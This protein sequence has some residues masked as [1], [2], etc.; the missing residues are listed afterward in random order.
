MSYL[1]AYAVPVALALA[2]TLDRI[3]AEPPASVHPIVHFGTV[4]SY[5]DRPWNRPRLVGAL[6]AVSLPL[7]FG[8]GTASVVVIA[9]LLDGRAGPIVAGAVVYSLFSHRMLIETAIEVV[10]LLESDLD[11]A[12][13]RLRALAGRDASSLSPPQVRSAVV[14]SAAENLADGLVSPLGAFTV[15]SIAAT[16]SMD[17]IA[18]TAPVEAIAVAPSIGITDAQ[19]VALAVGVAAAAWV[20]GVNTMD[21]MIGYPDKRVGTASARLDDVVMWL[22]AR[23]SAVLLTIAAYS[24]DPILAA[25]RWASAPP[26]PN[27]GWPMATVA[28]AL[29]VTLE[30]P[31]VYVLNELASLP[32]RREAIDGVELVSRAAWIFVAACLLAS[33]WTVGALGGGWS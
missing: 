6:A 30:K 23:G 22:P 13:R 32:T 26:S 18:A 27:S 24:P 11:A 14:E 4:V 31:G 21:S 16:V 9:G 15:G 28:A 25:R 20:K 10:D 17:S 2:V 19:T 3:R 12:R 7:A 33:L 5:L 1:L 29:H 8:A